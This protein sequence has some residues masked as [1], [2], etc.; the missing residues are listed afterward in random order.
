MKKYLYSIGIHILLLL[1]LLSF[2][3]WPPPV[4][5]PMIHAI[6]VDFSTTDKVAFVPTPTPTPTP[7]PKDN[8][9]KPTKP[10]S[11]KSEKPIKKEPTT[12]KK[13]N[14]SLTTTEQVVKEKSEAAAKQKAK[15]IEDR[16]A[17]EAARVEAERKKQEEERR[18]KE[19]EAKEKAEK[20]DYFKNLIDKSLSQAKNSNKNNKSQ[21]LP[22]KVPEHSSMNGPISGEI[23]NRKVIKVPSIMDKS[24]KEGRVVVKI[25]VNAQGKVISSK[26]TQIGS[27]TTDNLLIKL[28]EDGAKDYLFSSA[29]I[30][31][32]CGRVVIDFTLRA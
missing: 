22:E 31:R 24:Q 28:A 3:S 15:L 17:I 7:T 14:T 23:S 6:V 9:Q 13:D 21:E 26:Y 2:R 25:C 18:Q 19:E 29:D 12:P 5:E 10:I 30:E 32:Q 20:V 27:T 16:A 4:Q 11:K 8:I 1:W